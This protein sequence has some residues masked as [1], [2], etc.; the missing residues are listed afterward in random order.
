MNLLPII[1]TLLAW[2]LL[3]ETIQKYQ[4]VGG[5]ITLLGVALG[6]TPNLWRLSSRSR[7]SQE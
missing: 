4:L 3:S 6:V 1:V 2:V 5:L 7:Q